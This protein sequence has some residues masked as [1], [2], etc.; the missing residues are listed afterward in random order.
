MEGTPLKPFVLDFGLVR[1]QE[2]S[3]LTATGIIVGTPQYMSPEQAQA[4]PH[5]IDRRSD[6]YSLGATM[7]EILTG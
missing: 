4:E 6:I 7:Y 5:K 3:G 1:E 2:S